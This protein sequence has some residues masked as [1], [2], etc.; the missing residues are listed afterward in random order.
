MKDQEITHR[1]L[2]D[3]KITKN[4]LTL[5]AEILE[6]EIANENYLSECNADVVNMLRIAFNKIAGILRSEGVGM[7][8]AMLFKLCET[9]RGGS[10]PEC[11]NPD[12][13]AGIIE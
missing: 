7:C 12:C 9:C 11:D 13:N 5:V 4:E 6:D 10:L 3:A 2:T 8:D 1:F